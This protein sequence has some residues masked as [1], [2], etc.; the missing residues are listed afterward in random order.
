MIFSVSARN[1]LDAKRRGDTRDLESSGLVAIEDYL[2]GYFVNEKTRTLVEAVATKAKGILSEAIAELDLRGSVLKM[3]LDELA[4]K[5]QLFELALRSVEEQRRVIHDLLGGQQRRLVA[6]LKSQT[7][8]LYEDICAKLSEV[9]DQE[10]AVV[11]P[12]VWTEAAQ[13]R[14]AAAIE[15]VFDSAREQFI[16]SFSADT[17]S[18]FSAHQHRLEELINDVRR[19]AADIFE[20]QFHRGSEEA[21]FQLTNDPYWVT[22]HVREALI[23]DPSGVLDRLLPRRLRQMRTR[24]R[25]IARTNELVLRNTSSLHWAILQSLNDT[26]RKAGSQFEER[27]DDAIRATRAVIEATLER[28]RVRSVDVEP[29]I[30]RLDVLRASFLACRADLGATRYVEGAHAPDATD[31][32]LCGASQLRPGSG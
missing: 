32:S 4:S 9:I 20:V 26:F 14:L 2:R 28:G 24:K 19:A 7:D 15:T 29:E 30:A 11:W 23:P 21:A 16:R 31:G 6:D 12:P 17:N 10:L 8:D 3:P 22:R 5:S 27:L 1:S 13:K 18:T 25:L